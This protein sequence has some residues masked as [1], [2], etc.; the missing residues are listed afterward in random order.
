L[1]LQRSPDVRVAGVATV[2]TQDEDVA[3]RHNQLRREVVGRLLDVRLVEL[4]A[5]DVNA[6]T[7]AIAVRVAYGVGVGLDFDGLALN[8]DHALDEVLRLLNRSLE[9]HDVS[10]LWP[11]EEILHIRLE[12]GV[13]EPGEE[14]GVITEIE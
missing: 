11:A 9:D 13:G 8:G 1:G 7:A 4:D 10:T 5:V 2:V 6:A 12:A 3:G 14:V